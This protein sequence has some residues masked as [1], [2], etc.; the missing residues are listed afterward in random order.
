MRY[1]ERV[2]FDIG[3]RASAIAFSS[4]PMLVYLKPDAQAVVEESANGFPGDA[5][6][7]DV[8]PPAATGVVFMSRPIIGLDTQ[9]EGAHTETNAYVWAPYTMSDG[10]W[11]RGGDPAEGGFIVAS[12]AYA[13]THDGAGVPRQVWS[14]FGTSSW[15]FDEPVGAVNESNINDLADMEAAKVEVEHDKRFM[16]ALWALMA[17]DSAQL[18]TWQPNGNAK[19]RKRKGRPPQK[20]VVVNMRAAERHASQPADGTVEWT[21]RW[22]VRAHW[23]WQAH[24]PGRKQRKLILVPAHVKGPA[25]KPLAVKSK[26]YTP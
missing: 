23:R 5:S 16:A 1:S 22:V 15:R 24:G 11:M 21:H 10:E 18:D 14:P 20:V 6:M 2:E 26:V 13:E 9:D 3:Y 7:M 17:S 19:R 8:P 4:G 12:W 25:D